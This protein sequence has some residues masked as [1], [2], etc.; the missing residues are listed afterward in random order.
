[1]VFI[2]VVLFPHQYKTKTPKPFHQCR[3][4]D[5]CIA[6]HVEDPAGQRVIRKTHGR[7]IAGMDYAGRVR[8]QQEDH[9][10]AGQSEFCK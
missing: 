10:E 1:M 9:Q 4:I 5:K 3:F 7:S 8:R 2:V 6:F